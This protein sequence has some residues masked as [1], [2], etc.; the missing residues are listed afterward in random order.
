M[1]MAYAKEFEN[2]EKVE[3]INCFTQS[4]YDFKKLGM[5][6]GTLDGR[7][8][9]DRRVRTLEYKRNEVREM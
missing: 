4:K 5:Y 2:R 8:L 7:L 3:V 6:R 1:A 9:P